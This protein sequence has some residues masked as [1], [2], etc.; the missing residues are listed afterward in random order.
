MLQIKCPHCGMVHNAPSGVVGR[1]VTCKACKSDF[2]APKP[3]GSGAPPPVHSADRPWSLHVDGDTQGPYSLKSVIEQIQ[4]EEIGGSTLAW[5][6]GMDDWT[7]LGELVVFHDALAA[8]RESHSSAAGRAGVGVAVRASRIGARQGSVR[9]SGVADEEPGEHRRHYYPRGRGK[10]DLIIGAWVAGFMAVAALVVVLVVTNMPEPV[11]EEPTA[12]PAA[13]RA[14]NP[15]GPQPPAPG[16]PAAK[17]AGPRA[18][19]VVPAK[20]LARAIRDLERR[21]PAAIAGHKKGNPRP[22]GDLIRYLELHSE[23]LGELQ[24]GEHQQQMSRFISL[25]KKRAAGIRD[26][27]S[28]K[29]WRSGGLG[30]LGVDEK[31]KVESLRLNEYEWL[32]NNINIIRDAIKKLRDSG[33]K[34]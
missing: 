15:Q 25:L 4:E 21:F 28:T 24:W 2:R 23:Q 22:I 19:V 29:P 1:Q 16:T 14:A 5:R 26:E 3:P 13:P 33:W 18:P 27:L 11:V 32:E 34:I 6:D 17:K 31:T 20:R 30:A 10:R 9:G 7:P 12:P 8:A